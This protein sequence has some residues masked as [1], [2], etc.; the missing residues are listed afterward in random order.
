MICSKLC[1]VFG[2]VTFHHILVLVLL[3]FALFW[4]VIP[5]NWA[6]SNSFSWGDHGHNLEKLQFDRSQNYSYVSL[7]HPLSLSLSLYLQITRRIIVIY[8]IVCVI[9]L[10]PKNPDLSRKI[11]GLM[12]ETSQSPD[13]RIQ[14]Y[15][16]C[17]PFPDG[18]AWILTWRI[19]PLS[20]WLV[21]PI[22]RPFGPFIRGTTLLRGLTIT[23]VTNHLLTGILQ[24]GICKPLY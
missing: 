7:T 5:L 10:F 11:V 23:M 16:R 6:G 20:K 17:N 8:M 9:Y 4:M 3:L 2:L 18:R 15:L 14:G 22:Y 1:I 19:P 13:H 24:V 21:T 12:V